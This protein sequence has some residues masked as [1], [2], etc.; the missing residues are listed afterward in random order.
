M[1]AHVLQFDISG[2]GHCLYT[3]TLDLTAIGPLEVNRA[4]TIEFN[5]KTQQWELRN[6]QGQHLYANASRQLCLDWEHQYFNPIP[7]EC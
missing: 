1:N 5:Q 3:E 7:E 2:M 6:A 4:S